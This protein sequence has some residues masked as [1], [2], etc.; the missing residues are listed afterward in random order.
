MIKSTQWQGFVAGSLEIS[1]LRINYILII[2]PFFIKISIF[3]F[4]VEFAGDN[5]VRISGDTV[6]HAKSQM[7]SW[8]AGA[9]GLDVHALAEPTKLEALKKEYEAK[10]TDFKGDAKQGRKKL[11]CCAFSE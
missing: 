2:E 4:Q 1:A 6:S 10:K 5:F 8:E 3:F 11:F 7:F 9:K